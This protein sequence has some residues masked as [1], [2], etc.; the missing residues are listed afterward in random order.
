MDKDNEY[1]N[2]EAF[3]APKDGGEPIHYKGMWPWVI[4]YIRWSDG[5]EEHIADADDISRALRSFASEKEA[6]RGAQQKIHRVYGDPFFQEPGEDLNR[7]VTVAFTVAH[8]DGAGRSEHVYVTTP[9]KCTSLNCT[10]DRL[11]RFGIEL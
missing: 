3:S 11:A 10:D 8:C 1:L 6:I 2:N 7:E 5:F 9:A 4:E